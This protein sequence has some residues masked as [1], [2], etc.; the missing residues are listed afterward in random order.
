VAQPGEGQGL[1]AEALAGGIVCRSADGQNLD[2]HIAV[3]AGIACA[4][5]F[6]HAASTELFHNAVLGERFAD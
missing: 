3:Q 5:H 2:G 1:F 4:V 6:A